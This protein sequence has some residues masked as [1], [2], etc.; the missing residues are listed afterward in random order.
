MPRVVR[1]ASDLSVFVAARKALLFITCTIRRP[2]RLY[3]TD[4]CLRLRVTR[5]IQAASPDSLYGN[6]MGSAIRSQMY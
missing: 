5:V 1:C 6:Q 2:C 3:L 4:S